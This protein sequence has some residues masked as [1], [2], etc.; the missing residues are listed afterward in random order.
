MEND[1][2]YKNASSKDINS[3]RGFIGSKTTF[4]QTTDVNKK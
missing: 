4:N 2:L 3:N 1:N